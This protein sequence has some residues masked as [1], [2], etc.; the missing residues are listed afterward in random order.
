MN[1]ILTGG[2]LG[3]TQIQWISCGILPDGRE[4]QII[5][6]YMYAKCDDTTAVFIGINQ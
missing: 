4:F 1:I 5:N 3:G 6:T 2:P